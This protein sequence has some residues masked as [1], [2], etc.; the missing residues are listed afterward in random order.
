MN[1]YG[2]PY[3]HR[4]GDWTHGGNQN[5]FFKRSKIRKEVSDAKQNREKV[6]KTCKTDDDYI[7]AKRVGQQNNKKNKKGLFLVCSN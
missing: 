4:L 5:T 1:V 7:L 2:W 3:S 6:E